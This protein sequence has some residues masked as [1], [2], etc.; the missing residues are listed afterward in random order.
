MQHLL[1][2]GWVLIP[3]VSPEYLIN[4]HGKILNTV[5]GKIHPVHKNAKGF[6]QVVLKDEWGFSVVLLVHRLVA[7][8]FLK[9]PNHLVHLSPNELQVRH[10][11]ADKADNYVLNLEWMTA[12]EATQFHR[13]EYDYSNETSVIAKHLPSQ[14]LLTFKSISA[15]ARHAGIAQGAM[16]KHLNSD[17]AGRIQNAGWIY[18]IGIETDPWPDVIFPE[19]DHLRL[20]RAA[21]VVVSTEKETKYYVFNTVTEAVRLLGLNLIGVR[22]HF[23]RNGFHTPYHGYIF[24]TLEEFLKEIKQNDSLPRR[25]AVLSNSHSRL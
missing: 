14:E 2:D 24:Q 3:N 10:L 1:D 9:L 19:T 8:L 7:K 13:T 11:N 23:S 5:R 22:N 20:T 6:Y 15:A 4:D 12:F 18:Q 17:A 21:G 16:N 25:L